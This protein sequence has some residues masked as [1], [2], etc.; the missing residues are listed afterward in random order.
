[1]KDEAK[2]LSYYTKLLDEADDLIFLECQ[3]LF[4]YNK[5]MKALHKKSFEILQKEEVQKVPSEMVKEFKNLKQAIKITKSHLNYLS[6]KKLELETS[7]DI[8]KSHSYDNF[9][10]H[11]DRNL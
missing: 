2:I 3:N 10:Y 8:V 11:H 9:I 7:I 1:M 6:D 5:K 4:R